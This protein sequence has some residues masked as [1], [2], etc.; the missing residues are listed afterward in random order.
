MIHL[1]IRYGTTLEKPETILSGQLSKQS[2]IT[3]WQNRYF[4]LKKDGLFW[5]QSPVVY[6]F[7][8]KK[9]EIINLQFLFFF[10]L[11]KP[12]LGSH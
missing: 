2:P 3:V 11:G 6:L 9:K 5:Y 1:I 12:K 4:E 8:F 10:K 7:F